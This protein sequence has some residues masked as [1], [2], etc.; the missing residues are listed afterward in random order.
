[1]CGFVCC[2][3]VIARIKVTPSGTQ[4]KSAPCTPCANHDIVFDV[5]LSGNFDHSGVRR[6]QLS[7]SGSTPK[8]SQSVHCTPHALQQ[9]SLDCSRQRPA[10]VGC[11]PVELTSRSHRNHADDVHLVA[12]EHSRR[13]RRHRTRER[14]RSANR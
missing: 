1:M 14:H 11:S 10:A 4:A 7:C 5:D 3:C 8:L 9:Q 12:H 6:S 13:Q 2:F